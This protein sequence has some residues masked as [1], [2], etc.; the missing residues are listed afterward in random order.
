MLLPKIRAS[1]LVGKNRK[2][3][4][5]YEKK[6]QNIQPRFQTKGYSGSTSRTGNFVRIISKYD[7]HPNQISKWKTE[8]LD[9]ATHYLKTPTKNNKDKESVDINE[10]YAKIGQL[11]ME[12]DFLKKK[13]L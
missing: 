11:Q 3:G 8:F 2:L 1:V 10:L 7:L 4:T 6:T 9:N 5:D 12:L 13:L